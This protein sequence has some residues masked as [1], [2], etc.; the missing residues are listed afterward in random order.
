M[1]HSG[2]LE[3]PLLTSKFS[4]RKRRAINVPNT[5]THSLILTVLIGNARG[6]HEALPLFAHIHFGLP[7]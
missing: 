2:D 3:F 4:N 6:L 5:P 7:E 1:I